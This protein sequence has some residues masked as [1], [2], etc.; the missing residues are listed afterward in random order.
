ML[1]KEVEKTIREYGLLLPQEKV[2]VA[3]SGGAD[4]V[5]LLH[6]LLELRD[7]GPWELCVAHFNHQLRK[8]AEEDEAFVSKIALD[9]GLEFYSGSQDVR[10]YA[11]RNRLNLEEAGRKLRYTF[12]EKTAARIG[13]T[14][15][16]TAHTLNDQAETFLMRLLRGSGLRGLAGIAPIRDDLIVRPLL[17]VERKEIENYLSGKNLKYRV[18]KSNFDRRYLRNRIRL[19]LLPR[20]EQDYESQILLQIGRMSELIRSEDE[21]L[22]GRV[23]IAAGEVIKERDP[24]PVLDVAALRLQ[25]VALQRRLIRRYLNRLR[26][27]L[28]GISYGNVET[29]RNLGNG[30]EFVLDGGLTIRKQGE[31]I[32]LKPDSASRP[33]YD[34]VWDGSEALGLAELEI[35]ITGHKRECLDSGI[36]EFND[37]IG[38]SLDLNRLNFPLIVRNRRDGDRYQPLGAPGS[39]KLKEIFRAKAIPLEER[40]RR[41]VFLSGEEIVWV[42]GLPVAHKFRITPATTSIFKILIAPLPENDLS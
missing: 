1:Q 8:E 28:R 2:L 40:D 31:H 3:C 9:H 6:L 11:L 18:D 32:G 21:F 14:K 26:G 16:A 24:Q 37:E 25:P 41:P 20:L 38:A 15:I 4:S 19:D 34:Y 30:K 23:T 42:Q 36:S 39:A 22:E 12:L 7:R 27:N 29:I 33:K 35:E 13:A 5:C 17:Q 10:A